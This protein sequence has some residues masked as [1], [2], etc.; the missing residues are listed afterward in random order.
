MVS[1]FKEEMP[2]LPGVMKPVSSLT[3]AL[4]QW[5]VLFIQVR[6]HPMILQYG[7]GSGLFLQN[8]KEITL[9]G[10]PGKIELP[11]NHLFIPFKS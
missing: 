10:G 8:M 4:R 7:S 1:I 9:P 6:H 5:M 11:Y 3:E 2:R